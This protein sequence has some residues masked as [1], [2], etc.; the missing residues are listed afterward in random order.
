[1]PLNTNRRRESGLAEHE[2]AEWNRQ[3]TETQRQLAEKYTLENMITRAEVLNV[4]AL[5]KAFAEIADSLV[6]VIMSST[7]MSRSEKEDFLKNLS[8]W[9]VKLADVSHAQT[10]LYQK[11]EKAETPEAKNRRGRGRA[12]KRVSRR[13][14]KASGAEAVSQPG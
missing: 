14:A 5:K 6:S 8:T 13:V 10:R 12:S 3:R 11:E 9:T 4:T 7:S 2:L 1:M